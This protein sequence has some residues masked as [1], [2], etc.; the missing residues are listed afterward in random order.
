M[1]PNTRLSAADTADLADATASQVALHATQ[2]GELKTSVDALLAGQ[3]LILSRL[4]ALAPPRTPAPASASSTDTASLLGV[5]PAVPLIAPPALPVGGGGRLPQHLDVPSFSGVDPLG[6]I[7]R[8]EQYFDLNFT[9]L[10]DRVGTAIIGLDGSALHWARWLRQ[11]QPAISWAD[12]KQEMVSRYD[13]RY[14]G[15]AI[16]RLC[17]ARQSADLDTYIDEFVALVTQVPG[18]P[19]DHYLGFFLQGLVPSIR[20]RL[21]THNPR[22][23]S[24]AL[25]LARAVEADLG[26]RPPAAPHPPGHKHSTGRDHQPR[27]TGHV[28]ARTGRP[29]PPHRISNQDYND[30]R[31]KGLC[32]CCRQPYSP[33]HVCAV[34]EFHALFGDFDTEV[35]MAD[36]DALVLPDDDEPPGAAAALNILDLPFYSVGG[37]TGPRTMKMRGTIRGRPIIIMID[38]G[39]SHNFLSDDVAR[40]LELPSQSSP[41]FAVALGDGSRR[42]TL[43]RCDNVDF[44]IGAHTFTADFYAFALGGLDAILGV[45]WLQTLGDVRVNWAHMSMLFHHQD[46]PCRL[47]GDATLLRSPLSARSLNRITDATFAAWLWPMQSAASPAAPPSQDLQ[48]LIA[49]FSYIFTTPTGLPPVH[50]TDHPIVLQPES[51][52]ISVRPYRYGHTQKDEIERLV[53]EMLLG[54]LIRPSSSPFSSPVLLVRKKDGSWRFCVDYRELN[55]ATVADKY[56]IPVIQELLDELHGATFFTKLDLRAGYHQIRVRP[57]D[58]HKTAFR[59][60]DGHFEFVVMPFGLT[61]APATFQATMNDI[62][63]PVLRKHV[64]VFFDDI[65]VFSSTWQE[66]LLH[67]RQTFSTLRRHTLAVNQKKCSFGETCVHYLGHTISADGVAMDTDKVHAVLHWPTPTSLREVRGFLGL[68]GYYRRFIKDYG[69]IARPLT[70]L[71]K[72]SDDAP[73]AWPPAAT[74]A[75][76]ALQSALI[77]APVLAMPDFN[78]PFII[79]CD[80]SGTG[81]GAVLMQNGR[82][83]AYYSRAFSTAIRSR[84]AY[85]NELMALVLAVQHWR[86][87]LLG[88]PF[89]VRTDHHSLRYLLQ[90][91]IATPAQ[92]LWVA[93]LLGYDFT[94]EYR[95]G[96]SNK[97]ADALSRLTT[98]PELTAISRPVWD[99]ISTL[100]HEADNDPKLANIRRILLA[101]PTGHPPYSLIG[102]R[103]FHRNRLVLSSSSPSIPRLL[104]EFHSTPTD[105]HAGAFRTYRRLAA[106]LYWPSMMRQVKAYVAACLPCQKAKYETMFPGGLLQPLPVPERIWEDIAM[107]FITRLP[108]SNGFD[109]ILV[110]VD[111]L[112][113]YGHFLP[114]RHPYTATTVA[115]VFI[116]DVVRLHGFPRSIVSDRDPLFL[117]GFWTSLFKLQGTRLRM[118]TAYHPQ[119]DGQSEVLNRCLETYLR[120]FIGERPGSWAKWICWA[121]YSYNTSYHHAA[122]MTPFEAVYGR[123]PPSITRYLPGECPVPT[124]ADHLH[125]RDIILDSL[126]HHLHRAQGKMTSFANRKRRDLSF[127][128]GE[129]VF[130]KLHPYRQLSVARRPC[131]KLAPR[132]FGPFE[133]LSRIG[134]VAYRLRLPAESRIHP[135]FHVSQLR[136]VIGDHPAATHIPSDLDQAGSEPLY[137][138]NIID[139]RNHLPGNAAP[140]EVRVA[141]R[142]RPVTEATWLIRDDFRRQFPD[143]CLEDKDNFP[144][145][146]IVTDAVEEPPWRVYTRRARGNAD[147]S[148]ASDRPEDGDNTEPGG[149][150]GVLGGLGPGGSANWVAHA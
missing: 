112:T 59:T 54:G 79:E 78:Q 75:F 15:S 77:H 67:V 38:S 139:R 99:D 111:R 101:N 123:P 34:K 18:L 98:A 132:F 76:A 136:R 28:E 80:A 35:T 64:L 149:S 72:K 81:V 107:D 144:D 92:Q 2:I 40:A 103:L 19:P 83:I 118:S 71:L 127:Q 7:A 108:R 21:R 120:C 114:L 102:G 135:V 68:T 12:F 13:S 147:S 31:R 53:R 150:A 125:N 1:A 50:P 137:P 66:H 88:R 51:T 47:L 117:S 61:N 138:A 91:K 126:K 42:P 121:E 115:D 55:K 41:H 20:S 130:L 86:P 145:G 73:F 4:N 95:S 25:I 133:V 134:A 140:E 116:S 87:Y 6:W 128:V 74:A 11:S 26:Q 29:T 141:W 100:Q 131:P 94:I 57:E 124:L 52:A 119:T 56:L 65:L 105:G 104:A 148:E 143:Y 32:F 82:P 9:P 113:K 69:G 90:Q 8:A 63:R 85:E 37:I 36:F 16:E 106:T 23:V 110:V 14:T 10:P 22:T 39:A 146:G 62:F 96:K 89:I 48:A 5:P 70:Q 17:S 58:I 43:G 49:E 129:K 60:H 30:L 3:S 97:A 27:T 84:S 24:D 142:H 33:Q 46:Q 109:C 122:N 45:A 44:S 93:K